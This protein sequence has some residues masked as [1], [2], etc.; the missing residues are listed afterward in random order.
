MGARCQGVAGRDLSPRRV[1]L[2][3][4]LCA[5]GYALEPSR[6]WRSLFLRLCWF[7][8]RQQRDRRDKK[9]RGEGKRP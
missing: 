3:Q 5:V 2:R 4:R 6:E 7:R 8:A 9:S 1:A